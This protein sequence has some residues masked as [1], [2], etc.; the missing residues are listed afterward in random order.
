LLCVQINQ[1][2]IIHQGLATMTKTFWNTDTEIFSSD[3]IAEY[4]C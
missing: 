1:A 2:Q 3:S 4:H